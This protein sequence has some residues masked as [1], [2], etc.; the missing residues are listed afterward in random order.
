VE[1]LL[2]AGMTLGAVIMLSATRRLIRIEGRLFERGNLSVLALAIAGYV[3]WLL[4]CTRRSVGVLPGDG[5]L[6][7]PVPREILAGIGSDRE[8]AVPLP[9]VSGRRCRDAAPVFHMAFQ[10]IK[11]AG[12]GTTVY[13]APVPKGTGGILERLRSAFNIQWDSMTGLLGTSFWRA[14]S[15]I[16]LFL[17]AWVAL[18]SVVPRGSSSASSRRVGGARVPGLSG[19]ATARYYIRRWRSSA[20]RLLCFCQELTLAATARR[21]RGP[22]L[23]PGQCEQLEGHGDGVGQWR[24]DANLAVRLVAD[25]NPQR[26][27]VY[28]SGLEEEVADAFPSWSRCA[29][30]FRQEHAAS[31]SKPSC[32]AAT[33]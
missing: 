10:I 31:G 24:Q 6:P 33:S 32:S 26:C 8:A 14:L 18:A 2:V 29:S 20:L 22:R 9:R 7:L 15:V 4:A 30:R 17:V 23:R 21:G 28:M 16:L 1:P 13:G 27:R 25:L 5:A 19:T 12:E 11:L 3:L